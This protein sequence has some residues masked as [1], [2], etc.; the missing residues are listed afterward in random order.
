MCTIIVAWKRW[1]RVPLVIAANRDERLGRPAEPPSLWPGDG[2]A[3]VAPRDVEAGGTWVGLNA[4]GV[5]CGITNRFDPATLGRKAPASRGRV[6]TAALGATSAREAVAAAER[7]AVGTHPF[8]LIV[9][10]RTSARLVLHDGRTLSTQVL[11]PGVH[12][13]TQSSHGAGPGLR[14]ERLAAR[15]STELSEDAPPSWA[16][17]RALLSVHDERAP[18]DET[19]VH[20]AEAGYG[21]RSSTY[22]RLADDPGGDEL[23]HADGPPCVTA[24]RSQHE[25]LARLRGAVG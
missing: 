14:A 18:L 10:D 19:C 4:A 1:S 12:V 8:H 3:F 11:D 23:W 15:L 13:V 24:P 17:W 16:R 21:T 5:F 22:V 9:A 2:L 20:M 25:L 6:V 7:S